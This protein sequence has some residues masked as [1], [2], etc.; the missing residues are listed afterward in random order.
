MGYLSRHTR[1]SS[2]TEVQQMTTSLKGKESVEPFKG[3]ERCKW[4]E[5]GLPIIL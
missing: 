3:A 2:G 4:P 5:T 1:F